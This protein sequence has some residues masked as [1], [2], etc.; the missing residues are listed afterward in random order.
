MALLRLI[1][2]RHA[3][4]A[5]DTGAASDHERPL[6]GRGRKDAPR[7]A[8]AL[9]EM[10]WLPDHVISSD[11]LRTQQTWAR[12]EAS[13]PRTTAHFTRQLFH[14]D[15][16]DALRTLRQLAPDSATTL[17]VLGHN[18][19]LEELVHLLTRQDIVMTTANAVLLQREADSWHL[20][21]DG[22]SWTLVDVIRPRDLD[23]DS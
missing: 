15:G 10:D 12:M 20:A 17:L 8:H 23:S 18:P 22:T 2:M 14:A 11:S 3:K 16:R 6:S 1:V 4:S 19:G 7:V 13:F 9:A 5:W 21:L